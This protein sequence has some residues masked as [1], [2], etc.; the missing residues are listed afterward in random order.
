MAFRQLVWALAVAVGGCAV[1]PAD[2]P[3]AMAIVGEDQ[4]LGEKKPFVVV[5]ID[6]KV[7]NIVGQ[8]NPPSFS[9]FFQVADNVPVIRVA[10]GDRVAINIFEAGADGLFSSATAKATQIESVVDASGQIFVPYVGAIQADGRSVEDLRGT[11]EA[12][13]EDKAIQPQVQV[14]VSESLANSVTVLGDVNAP[15]QVPV[16]V[17]GLRL[18]DVISLAGGSSAETYETQVV[19]RRGNTVAT[20]NLEDLFDNPEDNIPIQPGDTVL[21]SDI[22]RSFTVFGAFNNKAEFPFEARRVTLAEAIAKAGGVNGQVGDARAIFL[23]RFELAEVAKAIDERA[24]AAPDGTK[25]PVVYRLNLREPNAFFLMTLFNLRDE[26]IVYVATHP[27]A[28]LGQFLQI[29][30]PVI[31]TAVTVATLTDRVGNNN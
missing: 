8:Y 22:S 30:A 5:K 23:F 11:I 24:V 12:A 17:A 15:G 3:P 9:S 21:V 19:L 14:S 28:Q 16:S 7:T 29:L 4:P 1:V 26:D 20:S 2:G 6:E 18:L 27:S 10:T 13:L 25:V 31:Q